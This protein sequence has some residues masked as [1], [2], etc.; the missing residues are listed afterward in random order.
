MKRLMMA[1]AFG[2]A[3]CAYAA[4]TTWYVAENGDG[5]GGEIPHLPEIKHI[6]K[7]CVKQAYDEQ[8]DSL[9]P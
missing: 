7:A 2:G 8:Q 4:A 6:G 5:L 3:F 1:I 9:Q